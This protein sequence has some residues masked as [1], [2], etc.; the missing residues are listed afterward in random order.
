MY[1]EQAYVERCHCDTAAV[2]PCASCGRA[3][4]ERHLERELCNRCTQLISAE[5]EKRSVRPWRSGGITGSGF[6]RG[7][8]LRPP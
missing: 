4:C 1:R 2:G 5:P 7:E 8:L 6:A 3:R